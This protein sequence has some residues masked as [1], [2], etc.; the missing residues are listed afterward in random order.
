MIDSG[1]SE[2]QYGV[3]GSWNIAVGFDFQPKKIAPRL[4]DLCRACRHPA[5]GTADKQQLAVWGDYALL[6]L[7]GMASVGQPCGSKFNLIAR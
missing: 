4:P 2:G 5:P 3:V 7:Q 1:R 6:G